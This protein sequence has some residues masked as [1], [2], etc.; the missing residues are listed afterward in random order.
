MCRLS[1]TRPWKVLV[2]YLHLKFSIPACLRRWMMYDLLLP[3]LVL[4]YLHRYVPSGVR[5]I[6]EASSALAIRSASS[7]ERPLTRL[8][9]EPVLEPATR[10]EAG[11][12]GVPNS[13]PFSLESWDSV[14]LMKSSGRS[15]P[16]AKAAS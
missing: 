9:A 10:P 4:Q 14:P 6:S 7:S 11:G 13:D 5:G 2:Q 8:G 16:N 3:S 1:F 12:S 15:P